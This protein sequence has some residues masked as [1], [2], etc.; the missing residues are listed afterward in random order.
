MLP[1]GARAHLSFVQVSERGLWVGARGKKI[2]E[3]PLYDG[4]GVIIAI[5]DSGVDPG[6][7]MF[8]LHL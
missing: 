2:Q 8:S 1:K 5:L 6:V 7:V 3:N 4:R